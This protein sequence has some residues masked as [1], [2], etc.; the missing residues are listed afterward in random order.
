MGFSDVVARRAAE[1]TYTSVPFAAG[2]VRAWATISAMS[3]SAERQVRER[4]RAGYEG[5]RPDIQA[6]VPSGV[7]RILEIGCSTGALGAALRQRDGAFVMGVE[8]DAAYARTA[9]EVLDEVITEDVEQF[10]RE[11]PPTDPPF[12]CLIGADVFE[13]LVDPWEA[14]SSAARLLAPGAVVVVS[15]PNVLNMKGIWRVVVGGTWPREDEGI[16]DRTHLRWFTLKD[17]VALVAGAGLRLE[18]VTGNYPGRGLRG[19]VVRLLAHLGLR[20]FLAV[21]W[22]VVASKPGRS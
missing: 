20:R 19:A 11:R 4:R 17:A 10:L 9:A 8:R 15:V 6:L 16:F 18:R 14:M 7:R 5:A 12:D 22:V 2:P 1:S 3:A 13:H 21:Q